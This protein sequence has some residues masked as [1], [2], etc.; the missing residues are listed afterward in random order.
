MIKAELDR[1]LMIRLKDTPGALSE[2]TSVISHAGI[3]MLALCAYA[4][5][6]VAAIMFVTED[7]N[8]AKQLLEKMGFNVQEE[9]VVLL[10]LDNKPGALQRVLDKIA[11]A[12]VD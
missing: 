8:G 10:T 5:E 4:L 11:E 7:N 2:I 3:N 1:Q 6:G 12:N 9:E